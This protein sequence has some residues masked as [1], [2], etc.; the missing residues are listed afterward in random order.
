RFFRHARGTEMRDS[1]GG[2][3]PVAWPGRRTVLTLALGVGVGLPLARLGGA[4]DSSARGAR[5]QPND[6]FV[7]A[8]GE[9]KGRLITLAD[10]PALPVKVADGLPVVAGAF[11]GR[12][13]FESGGG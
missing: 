4:Q 1:P 9:R 6:R 8:A 5:P 7:L 11:I 10:L 2:P 3:A 13:G 12:P